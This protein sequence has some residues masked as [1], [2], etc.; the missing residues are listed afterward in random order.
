MTALLQICAQLSYISVNDISRVVASL[1]KG[2]LLAKVDI[3]SVYRRI[4][5]VH[6][7][8]R[9]LLGMQWK[10]ELYVDTCLPFGLW[11]AP[12]I[13]TAVANMLEQCAKEQG[14]THLLHY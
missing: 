5:P 9:L 11:S 6:P 14:V 3:K 8:D 1:R 13:F 12:R 10:G 4:M 2:A 7:D